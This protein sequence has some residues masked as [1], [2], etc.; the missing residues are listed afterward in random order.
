MS[1]QEQEC[2]RDFLAEAAYW[3]TAGTLGFAALGIARMP[4]PGVLPGKSGAVK[5]G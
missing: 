3:T 5:I 2:R 1:E 4:R